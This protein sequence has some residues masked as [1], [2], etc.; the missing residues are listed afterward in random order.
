MY[1]AQASINMLSAASL[2]SM[3][4]MG[5]TDFQIICGMVII[6]S[7]IVVHPSWHGAGSLQASH[8][9]TRVV[10]HSFTSFSTMRIFEG[11]L[12]TPL[13]HVAATRSENELKTCDGGG[14]GEAIVTHIG[15]TRMRKLGSSRRRWSGTCA[16]T[17][18]RWWCRLGT[19]PRRTRTPIGSCVDSSL[20]VLVAP[21]S[22]LC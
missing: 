17:A 6:F 9:H 13:S 5:L 22:R 16:R 20:A 3:V 1:Y 4:C 21:S 11:Q 18:C 7:L 8:S 19:S 10:Q 14:D 15:R 12:I 2:I